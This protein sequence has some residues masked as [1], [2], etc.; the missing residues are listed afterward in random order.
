MVVRIDLAALKCEL[1]IQA[2]SQALRAGQ[3]TTR[4]ALGT[5]GKTMA[6]EFIGGPANG[7]SLNFIRT[8]IMLRVVHSTQ[9]CADGRQYEKWDALNELEDTA[10]DGETISIYRL[11]GQPGWVHL[12]GRD[13]ITGKRFGRTEI[14]A[15]YHFEEVQP[16]DANVRDNAKWAAWCE[17]NRE[18]IME[19]RK[20]QA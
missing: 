5:K 17:A 1:T 20:Q 6:I 12:D 13:K 19:S 7:V 16:A 3:R 4:P 14:S 8:P 18:R 11:V 2:S 10:A 15:E 9:T